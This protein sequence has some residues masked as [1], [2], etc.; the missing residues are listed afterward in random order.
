MFVCVGNQYVGDIKF[1]KPAYNNRSSCLLRTVFLMDVMKM[2]LA[3]ISMES[4]NCM[5]KLSRAFVA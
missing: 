4:Q 1:F 5:S 2:S 3:N